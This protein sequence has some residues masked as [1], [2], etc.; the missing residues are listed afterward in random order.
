[1]IKELTGLKDNSEVTSE[2]VLIWAQGVEPH[3]VQKAT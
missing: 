1:M 2:Q 3:R